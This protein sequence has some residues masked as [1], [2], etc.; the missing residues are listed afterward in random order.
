MIVI[1][2][3]IIINHYHQYHYYYKS[4]VFVSYCCFNKLPQS[5]WL[6]ILSYSSVGHKS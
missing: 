3:I 5:Y 2:V 4:P 6:K 1:L